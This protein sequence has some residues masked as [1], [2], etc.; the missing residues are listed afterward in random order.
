MTI[1]GGAGLQA[2]N[3]E[4]C[5]SIHAVTQYADRVERTGNE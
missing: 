1:N 5:P 3:G 4:S 2:W